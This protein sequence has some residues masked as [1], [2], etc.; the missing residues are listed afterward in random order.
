MQ[1]RVEWELVTDD[2]RLAEL[3]E[4]WRHAT[5]LALD[6]EFI[7][8]NT[9]YPIA[10]V[11]QVSDGSEVV[12][13]D[14]VKLTQWDP[15]AA[16]LQNPA[17]LKLLHSGSEDLVL[18][19]HFFGCL[20]EPLFDTQKAAGFVGHGYSISYQNLVRELIGVELIKARSEE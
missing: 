12:L 10:G 1:Q 8:I 6:T 3:C 18:F 5:A 16:L 15:F 7:R 4:R 19:Q 13:L 11:I 17:I 2:H 20:P 9:F 14:A